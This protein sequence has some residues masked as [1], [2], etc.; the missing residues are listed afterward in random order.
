[1]VG[2]TLTEIRNRTDAP[3]S[4][5]G[6]GDT[7]RGRTGNRPV[8]VPALRFGDHVTAWGVVRA[9]EQ[10]RAALRRYHP[11]RHSCDFVV[12]RETTPLDDDRRLAVTLAEETG[13]EG[14]VS[15]STRSEV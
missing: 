2:K 7:V 9:V 6:E 12:R 10:Y 14:P 1:M 13:P 11:R 5:V 15:A 8:P 4:A 3:A